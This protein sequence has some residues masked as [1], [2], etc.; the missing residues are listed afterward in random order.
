MGICVPPK[1]YFYGLKE[2]EQFEKFVVEWD[3][4]IYS[5][6]K[7][8][9]LLFKNNPNVVSLL[10][11]KDEHYIK[12]TIYGERIIKNRD[13][14]SCKVA[15]KTFCGY[16]KDQLHRMTHGAYQGYM[17]DK[18]KKLVSKYGYDCKN[19]AHLIRLLNMG[20]GRKFGE[21]KNEKINYRTFEATKLIIC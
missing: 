16:A 8:V 20:I 18:R 10:W 12:K 19:A 15:Y 2:F 17:G 7:F 6:K 3:V 4:V 5:L 1:R 21:S 14:F 9:K 11:L 13:I